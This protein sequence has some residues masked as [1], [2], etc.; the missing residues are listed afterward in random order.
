VSLKASS[1]AGHLLIVATF[2]DKRYQAG[3]TPTC[4]LNVTASSFERATK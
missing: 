4:Q 2:T 1:H 3:K